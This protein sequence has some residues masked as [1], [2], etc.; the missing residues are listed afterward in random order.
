MSVRLLGAWQAGEATI[1]TG[2][3]D[4]ESFLWL[5]IWG[6]VYASK[7]ID[8]ATDVNP[9]IKLMLKAWSGDANSNIAKLGHTEYNWTDAVFGDLIKNW[10]GIF[11]NVGDFNKEV[12]HEMSSMSPGSDEWGKACEELESACNYVYKEIL[13]SGFRHLSSV[14]DYHTWDRVV[15]ANS[16]KTIRKRFKVPGG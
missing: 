5:L 2:L 7:E 9:G 10:L 8:G 16:R 4:L 11:R 6:I 15:A 3:D 13:G 1:H 14:S 12:A